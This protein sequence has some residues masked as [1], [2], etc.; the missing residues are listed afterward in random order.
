MRI[1]QSAIESPMNSTCLK[2]G[3]SVGSLP[4]ASRIY[5]IDPLQD[6][7]WAVFTQTHCHASVFHSTNWLTA[8]QSTYG[9]QPVAF[10]PAGPGEQLKSG[11]V[12]C[13][14]KSRLTGMRMVSLP[15]SDHCEPLVD[16][17]AELDMILGHLPRL[18]SNENGKYIEVRPLT[19]KPSGSTGFTSG[20]AYFSHTIDLTGSTE[21][22]FR[23]FHKDCVQRKVRRA[24]RE[25]LTYEVGSS[26]DLL[27]RFYTLLVMTRRRHHLPPQPLCW[28]RSLSQ[29]FGNKMQVRLASQQGRPVASILTLKSGG[30]VTYKYGCSDARFSNLGGTALL[31]WRTIQEAKQDG[32]TRFDLGR[33]DIDNQGL[34][35]F[36]EHLGAQRAPLQHWRFPDPTPSQKT[37]WSRNVS[38]SLVKIAPDWCL[39]AA[40][41][42]LYRH[43]G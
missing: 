6:S 35:R 20:A 7:R 17:Q 2:P 16:T 34:I 3:P 14:I 31:F 43:I 21:D 15:F 26:E 10:T 27:A 32:A 13:R 25:A 38:G 22:I 11:L 36:K 18:I 5:E 4:A 33:S 39:I 28:F 42:L 41:K 9:Y 37:D 1:I 24:E 29:A 23:A 8:L 30:T 12:F 40:G 19:G